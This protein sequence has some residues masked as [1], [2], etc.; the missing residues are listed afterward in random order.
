MNCVQGL[1]QF[2]LK[3]SFV[4]SSPNTQICKHWSSVLEGTRKKVVTELWQQKQNISLSQ[5]WNKKELN[6]KL[7]LFG[8]SSSAK[9]QKTSATLPIGLKG[10]AILFSFGWSSQCFSKEG[11]KEHQCAVPE[12]FLNPPQKGLELH[13]IHVHA[14]SFS[15]IKTMPASIKHWWNSTTHES[16]WHCYKCLNV[17]VWQ[18]LAKQLNGSMPHHLIKKAPD[19]KYVQGQTTIVPI[20]N[21]AI[22]LDGMAGYFA[23]LYV[24]VLHWHHQISLPLHLIYNFCTCWARLPEFHP[25]KPAFFF[26]QVF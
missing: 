20:S 17:F 10:S 1:D 15:H 6:I 4:N 2:L 9:V 23:P 18:D 16:V 22:F 12:N 3:W 26:H 21:H 11:G 5:F 7:R 14:F 19:Y 24:P 8:Q 25:F 13:H